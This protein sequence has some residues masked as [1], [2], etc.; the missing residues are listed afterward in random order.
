MRA[1]PGT[2]RR[3]GRRRARRL[4][5]AAAA[6]LA[7]PLSLT[8]G[9]D[10]TAQAAEIDCAVDYS[11]NDWGSGFTAAVAI[12]NEGS[13]PVDGWT[14]TYDYSGDQQLS[15]GWS[16]SWSQSG[17]TVTVENVSYNA[18]IPPGGTVTPGANFTYSGENT[19][20]TSFALNGVVCGGE[21]PEPT[22][23]AFT[24]T[25]QH[26]SVSP[27]D[28]AQVGVRLTAA[29]ESEVT[30]T[31]EHT[32][33][34][35]GLSVA[36][37]S[38]LTFTPSNWD[39]EQQVTLAADD[40]GS[41]TATFTVR[42]SGLDPV[43]FTATQIGGASGAYEERFLEQYAK[44]MD[45][46]N[47]YLS[48]EGIP[49]HSVETLIVEAPDHGHETTSEAYSYLIWLEAMYGKVTGDWAPFNEAWETME[50]YMIPTSEDQPTNGFY[51]PSSPATYAPEL[52]EPS[53][54]PSQLDSSVSVGQDPIASELSTTYGTDDIYG[55]HWLQDVDNVYGYGNSPG[56]C[57]AGPDDEGPSYINTFQRG[58]QESVWETVP[59]PTCDNFTYGGENGYLDLF[60]G[61]ASYAQQWKFTNAPDADAR[62]VQAAYWADK[63]AKEQ[64]N[65]GQ[66][67]GT[68]AKAAKMGDYL[69]Y[70]MYDKYFKKIGG[71]TSPSCP[72]G[73]GKD[74]AHYLL[75]WYYAWGGALDSS[76]GWSWRIGSSHAHGGYQNP[77]AAYALSSYEPLVPE[78]A[79]AGD[80]WAKSLDRQIEFY[81]WLQSDEGAIAGGATNSWKGRYASPPAGTS[82]FYGMYYDEKPVYH[83]PP[84]NQWFGFQAWSM[85]RVAEY[86]H[87]TGD[88]LAG[89]VVAKWVDWAL[90]ETTV[91]ADGFQFPSTMSWSG[92][93]DTW[94][95]DAP[96]ANADLHVTVEDY[97]NDVGV[98]AAYAKILTYYA[99]ASG[100]EQ[101]R[102]T[103]KGL[104][105][106]MQAH[107]DDLGIAV[108]ETRADYERFDD[109][110]YVPEGWTG[111][112][113]NGDTIDADSTFTS[114]RSF[115]Q[116]DP[117]W[118]KVQNYLDGGEA[119]SFTY[120]RFWA[121]AD[122]ALALGTYAEL[123]GE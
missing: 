78:S 88:A 107:E 87:Q 110:V 119:P 2:A 121:Q 27:G 47:G 104:L 108:P 67:A 30:A 37:G 5:V 76:A 39:T 13:E 40:T 61:D 8:G 41:G 65:G 28:T 35:T 100:D 26:V 17:Q 94:D 31:V 123:F 89:E 18:T 60:T 83:D 63:W 77:M 64:G 4:L 111:V 72:A 36:A 46:D 118:S 53:Q 99:A 91:S 66:V 44:I 24:V 79:T 59:Q 86:H 113:P 74:S 82:T 43:E 68:V 56:N 114:I 6:A 122:I 7:L 92:Q 21:D 80:D 70:A 95:P 49:Y 51:S 98:A 93:P 97:T 112:M 102:T 42:A 52:D 55:M 54:Y 23:P 109:P 85:E 38:S 20:P 14:L 22:E 96:G 19:A 57:Q 90:S 10:G 84:S 16:G 3:A 34:N 103:A 101:A 11:V 105:D 12:T 58:P 50:T 120:H 81:R 62:A 71:C 9:L 75:N 1:S 29:P 33:G 106:A 117:A 73:S 45:P 115:Y 116:D 15:Q 25:P 32:D 69:R 48:P